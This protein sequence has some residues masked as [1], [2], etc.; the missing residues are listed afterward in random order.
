MI[1][2]HCIRQS[3]EKRKTPKGQQWDWKLSEK[4]ESSWKW[5]CL[6]F[7]TSTQCLWMEC[8]RKW[9]ADLWRLSSPIT[10]KFSPFHKGITEVNHTGGK[11]HCS[12]AHT[13]LICFCGR[14]RCRAHAAKMEK[15]GICKRWEERFSKV[16]IYKTLDV[17]TMSAGVVSKGER[18]GGAGGEDYP[19]LRFSDSSSFPLNRNDAS[20]P[21]EKGKMGDRSVPWR[22][23][24]PPWP[25]FGGPRHHGQ[26]AEV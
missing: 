24:F 6:T 5:L 1:I 16:C 26:F 21:W 19:H 9:L 20:A 15:R 18:R 22:C 4:S 13:N 10:E 7:T 23:P 8:L 11:S 2:V 3:S 12:S 14:V 25:D 17:A